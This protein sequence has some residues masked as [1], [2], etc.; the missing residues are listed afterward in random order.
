M[1]ITYDTVADR[2]SCPDLTD[3]QTAQLQGLLSSALARN[4]PVREVAA[5]L[6]SYATTAKSSE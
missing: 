4:T 3:Q 2:I 6:M 1:K 5:L